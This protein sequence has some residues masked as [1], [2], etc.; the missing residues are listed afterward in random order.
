MIILEIAVAAP[1]DQTFS[2]RLPEEILDRLGDDLQSVIGRRVYIPFGPRKTTGY[3]FGYADGKKS[4]FQ[5]KDI[6]EVLDD[7][8]IFHRSVIKVFK[9]VAEYYH[10]PIGEVVKTALPGG[11]MVQSVKSLCLTEKRV[12]KDFWK[13]IFNRKNIHGLKG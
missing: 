10:Y 3:V 9:W 7:R 4:R 12:W 1:V 11:L 2:Y 6:L 13:G 5:L 8:P